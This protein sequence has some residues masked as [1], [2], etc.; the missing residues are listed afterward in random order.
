MA[1]KVKSHLA[2]RMRERGVSQYRVSLDTGIRPATLKK[3]RLG[4][5]VCLDL[6]TAAKLAA[7]LKLDN[8]DELIEII[9]TK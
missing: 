1:F 8:L 4:S 9:Y 2:E 6:G 5:M 3:F 7:Y